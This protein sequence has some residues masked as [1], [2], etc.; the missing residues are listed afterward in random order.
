MIDDRY[1]I[2][3]WRAW[4]SGGRTYDSTMTSWRALPPDGALVF[5]LYHRR[6]GHRRIMSGVSL[7]WRRVTESGIVFACDD[8]ADALLDGVD[9]QDLKHGKWVADE[10]F[11]AVHDAAVAAD[12][13][14]DETVRR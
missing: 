2:V 9:T 8:A 1:R 4:Y 12:E 6:P 14:P 5:V 11:L 13:A 10:E 3:G 7:Y